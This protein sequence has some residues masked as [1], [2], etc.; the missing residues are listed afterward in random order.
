MTCNDLSQHDPQNIS[1]QH[2]QLK[3]RPPLAWD[4]IRKT[5]TGP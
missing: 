1:L 3:T 5:H 4:K 2:L